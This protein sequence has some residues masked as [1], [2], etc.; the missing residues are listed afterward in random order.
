MMDV[1]LL[2]IINSMSQFSTLQKELENNSDGSKTR[3]PDA[4][5]VY[6]MSKNASYLDRFVKADKTKDIFM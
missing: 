2:Y 6:I 1:C 3:L 5:E 4:I